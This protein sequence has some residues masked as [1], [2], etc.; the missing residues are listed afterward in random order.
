M[1]NNQVSAQ[2]LLSKKIISTGQYS[3]D[4]RTENQTPLFEPDARRVTFTFTVWWLV[5]FKMSLSS[6]PL[7][8]TVIVL[9]SFFLAPVPGVQIV[10]GGRAQIYVSRKNSEGWGWER[11]KTSSSPPLRFVRFV[12]ERY[13]KL[14]PFGN[15]IA[16]KGQSKSYSFCSIKS[17][18]NYVF[19]TGTWK[20]G[21]GKAMKKD[22]SD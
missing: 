20:R 3:T 6:T 21:F 11:G 1:T 19:S 22:T 2:C 5:L 17:S 7:N 18:F 8:Q 4:E 13:E 10:G 12:L 15:G 9:V 16:G 14:L